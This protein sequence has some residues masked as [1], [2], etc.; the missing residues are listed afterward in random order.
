MPPKPDLSYTGLDEFDVKPV[1]ENKSSEVDTKAVRKNVDASIIKEWVLYDEEENVTEPKI[2]KKIVRPGIVKKEFVKPRQQE[3]IARKTGNQKKS[4]QDKEVIDSGCSRHMIGN[5]SSR[6]DNEEIDGGYVMKINPTIYDSCIEQF[7]SIAMAKNINGEVQIH[8]WVDDKEIINTKSSV[9][10]DL[11][12]ADEEG[13]DC[14]SNSTIFKNHELMGKPKRK[15]TQ[16]PQP[17]GSTKHVVDEAV[18]KE[19]DD[20]LDA[21]KQGRKINDVDADEDITL[22]NEQNDAEMFDVNYLNGEEVS[23]SSEV[24]VASITTTF[25]AV[26]TIITEEIT[27]AQELVEIKTS[28][29]KAKEIV[30]QEP[31]PVKLRKNDQV[32]FVEEISLKLQAEFAENQKVDDDK[33]ISER[34]ELMEIIPDKEEVA[35]DA[36]PLAVKEDLEDMYNLV[37]AKYGSTR[38]VEDLDLLLW[39]DLKTIFEPHVEDQVWKKKHRYRVL[40]WKLY[41]SCGV[42]SLRMQ[43]M[44]NYMLG[45]II[46]IKSHI[47]AV[48]IIIAHIDV[49]TALIESVLLVNFKENI[50][51]G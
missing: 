16:V 12:L 30:L 4:L 26:A 10:K 5:M 38:L 6:T 41:D 20:R 23:A 9:R 46:S 35:I 17:S 39:A 33:E 43:S 13:I 15:N 37:K 1:V 18:Y 32:S 50:L 3:K 28:K 19:L 22:V 45:R 51:S 25:S 36:I 7:W 31:K 27:L 48:G 47:D 24:I 14:L 44:H 8:A 21:S 34:K 42:H 49:N 11:Q 40:E 2:V 29:P